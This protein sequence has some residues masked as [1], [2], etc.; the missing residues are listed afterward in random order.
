MENSELKGFYTQTNEK[1]FYTQ[2]NEKPNEQKQSKS[3]KIGTD[4]KTFF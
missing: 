3:Q 1:S 4:G 2:P